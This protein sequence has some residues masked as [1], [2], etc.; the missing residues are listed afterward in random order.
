[1]LLALTWIVYDLPA[2]QFS[3]LSLSSF[4]VPVLIVGH[5]VFLLYWTAQKS[6]KILLSLISLLVS[7]FIFGQFYQISGSQGPV[8]GHGFKVMTYN[9]RN[10]NKNEQLPLVSVDSTIMDFIIGESPEVL[11]VQEAHYAMRRSTRLDDVYPYKFVDFEYGVPHPKV[12][13][14]MYS[15]FPIIKKAIIEFPESS[16]AALYADIALPNDTVRVYNVHLQSFRVVP[17]VDYLQNEGSDKLLKRIGR[18]LRLQEKQARLLQESLESSP[19]PV[20]LL[21]DFNN[22]QF[23]KTY[24]LM[25]EGLNDSFLEKGNGV[26]GTF[27]LFDLPVR[28]DYILADD[29][30]EIERHQNYLLRLSDHEPV[31]AQLRLRIDE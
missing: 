5:G 19:H 12:I 11:A 22:T 17:D 16:N 14:A 13:N 7:L 24:R 4:F 3:W 1:M 30:F 8:S 27:E 29:H 2:E 25:R 9:V 31:V 18:S 26:G 6:A 15:K 10:L 21:G 23:S 20:L 28:I